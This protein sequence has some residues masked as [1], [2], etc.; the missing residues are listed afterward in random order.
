MPDMKQACIEV[1]IGLCESQ[2]LSG[3]KAGKIQKA[4]GSAQN[5]V[6]DRRCPSLRQLSA[7]LQETFALV[8][9]E[10]ARYEVLSHNPQKAAIRYD[11]PDV[12]EL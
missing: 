1:D 9:A 5:S 11:C 6:P 8:S 2:K 10:H 3:P 12:F 7:S 4:Q